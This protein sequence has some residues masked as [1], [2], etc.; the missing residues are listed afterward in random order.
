MSVINY[1]PALTGYKPHGSKGGVTNNIIDKAALKNGTDNAIE[2]DESFVYSEIVRPRQQSMSVVSRYAQGGISTIQ[3]A[4]IELES[5]QSDL[6]E[7]RD[8]AEQLAF[9]ENQEIDHSDIKLSYSMLRF[10]LHSKWNQ[11]RF[12]VQQFF[13]AEGPVLLAMKEASEAYNKPVLLALR[14]LRA[15]GGSVL[16]N[17]SQELEVLEHE[18]E[19]FGS[20]ETP[21][22]AQQALSMI[23]GA[24]DEVSRIRAEFAFIRISFVDMIN[25][26][27]SRALE[28]KADESKAPESGKPKPKVESL[29]DEMRSRPQ[30]VK[31]T[32]ANL[33]PKKI[34][35]ILA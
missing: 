31:Y 32:H 10:K 2:N 26:L 24:M 12:D 6:M 7:M 17:N 13:S 29:F 3:A 14:S 25:E 15:Q 23:D 28:S 27:V 30:S 18:P 4:E 20:V 35:D 11:I 9:E 5:V 8:T 21:A 22:D 19:S 1:L 33:S 16:A 34:L